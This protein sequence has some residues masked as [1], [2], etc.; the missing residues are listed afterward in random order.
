MAAERKS[1]LIAGA[2]L[3]CIRM[4]GIADKYPTGP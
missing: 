2:S 4:E 3:R 1:A